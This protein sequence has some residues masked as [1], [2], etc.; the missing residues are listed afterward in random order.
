MIAVFKGGATTFGL[1]A[2][3]VKTAEMDAKNPINH[4]NILFI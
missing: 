1:F 2:P 3:F 4:F